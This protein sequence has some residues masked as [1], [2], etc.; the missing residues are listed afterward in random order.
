MTDEKATV[1]FPGV[2]DSNPY[3]KLL[4]KSLEEADINPI[5][6]SMP[7]FLPFTRSVID[8]PHIDVI[9]LDWL[10]YFYDADKLS[11]MPLINTLA[12][13]L[14]ALLF[15]IDILIISI[16]KTQIVWTIHNKRPHKEKYA[17]LEAV[18]NIFIA[19]IV[20]DITVKCCSAKRTII[21]SH[22]IYSPSKI[23]VIPDGNYINYYDNN[24]TKDT[25]RDHLDIDNEFVYMFFGM[26]HPYKGVINLIDTFKS[27]SDKNNCELWIIGNPA[28]DQIER[29]IYE[30]SKKSD[31]I[32]TQ[33]AFIPD[34]R[35]QYY[36][37]AADV[38][39][40][41]YNNILNSGSVHLGLSFAKPI[42]APQIGCIPATIP[43]ENE[44]L[45]NPT[46]KNGLHDSL[47][48]AQVS[49]LSSIEQA[50]Y[51]RAKYFDWKSIG[52]MYSRLYVNL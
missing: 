12:S 31:H 41:P 3:H 20:D 22:R 17:A 16:L 15:C 13:L 33:L 29:D 39:V 30:K 51:R 11:N 2:A 18:L 28:T 9:H 38:L 4:F 25:A 52:K 8:N 24:I 37:N 19:N 48:Q 45:Y 44:M 1:L 14:R 43:P 27:L 40:F 23:S 26:I 46:D 36:L 6:K 35:I 42:I 32:H 5:E 10:H 7:V 34:N 21:K 49:D 50:N 47:I